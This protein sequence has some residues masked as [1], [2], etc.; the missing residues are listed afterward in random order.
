MQFGTN[1]SVELRGERGCADY[2]KSEATELESIRQVAELVAMLVHDV[3]HLA[4]GAPV[5]GT[6][7]GALA[8]VLEAKPSTL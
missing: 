5:L 4:E 7:L 1:Y 6:I 2:T 3:S 8:R